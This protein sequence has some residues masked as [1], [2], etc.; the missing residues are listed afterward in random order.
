MGEK[1]DGIRN[2]EAFINALNA[3]KYGGYSDWR[4]PTIQELSSIVNHS[5][6]NLS[7]NTDYFPNTQVQVDQYVVIYWSSWP[8]SISITCSNSE[9][10]WC[11]DFRVGYDFNCKKSDSNYVRAVR[12]GQSVPFANLVVSDNETLSDTSTGLMLQQTSGLSMMTWKDA[13]SYCENLNLAGYTD[14]RLP[15]INELRFLINLHLYNCIIPNKDILFSNFN[16]YWSSSS[17][18][19]S[20]AWIGG[21][22]YGFGF[23][24]PKSWIYYVSCVR[25]GNTS[26][27]T[28]NIEIAQ[29]PLAGQPGTIFTQYGTG[30]TPN[31]KITLHI[32]DEPNEESTYITTARADGGFEIRFDSKE[33]PLGKYRWY[34]TDD[35]TGNRS[36]NELTYEITKDPFP[37]IGNFPQEGTV[38][39]VFEQIGTGFTP[40]NTATLVFMDENRNETGRREVNIDANGKFSI[41]YDPDDNKQ[42]GR[43]FWYAKDNAT[44]NTALEM[45]YRIVPAT[46]VPVQTN[47]RED[48]KAVP[49]KDPIKP[50]PGVL[51][52]TNEFDPA[53]PVTTI[54]VHGWNPDNLKSMDDVDWM[55][56]M[57]IFLSQSGKTNVL[58]YNWLTE[59]ASDAPPSQDRISEHGSILA[60][61]L[62]SQ[63][64]EKG[65]YS[66]KLH[67]IGHSAGAGVSYN[68][69]NV[70]YDMN[71][72]IPV[73]H[74]TMLDAFLFDGDKALNELK[75]LPNWSMG[76]GIPIIKATS[77]AFNYMP[78]SK[79]SF[80]DNYWT[81]VG[82]LSQ[83]FTIFPAISI[84][85]QGTQANI[86]DSLS[87]A[88]P[89]N[90]GML[91][92][93]LLS[94][95]DRV[96]DTSYFTKPEGFI[97]YF[98]DA[99]HATPINWYMASMVDQLRIAD[100][101]PSPNYQQH[102][103][104]YY[105][106]PVFSDHKRPA[107]ADLDYLV[108]VENNFRL[109]GSSEVLTDLKETAIEVGLEIKEGVET[110]IQ[111]G[112]DL[113]NRLEKSAEEM[114]TK[115]KVVAAD[116]F[117]SASNWVSSKTSNVIHK[118]KDGFKFFWMKSDSP[119]SLATDYAIPADAPFMA[120]SYR[121]LRADG[122]DVIDVFINDEMVYSK[123]AADDLNKD[124][125]LSEWINVAKWAGQT[126]LLTFRIYSADGEPIEIEL[127]D[128]VFA[129]LGDIDKAVKL[130]SDKDGMP[131]LWEAVYLG[132]TNQDGT[133]DAD[134]DGIRDIDEYKNG[135]DPLKAESGSKEITAS[136]TANAGTDQTVNERSTVTLQGSAVSG[137]VSYQWTMAGKA[138]DWI[139]TPTL[140]NPNSPNPTF[141]AP[142]V[143]IDGG[144][145]VFQLI[146]TDST[147][148]QSSDVCD[149]RI[150]NIDS[151]VSEDAEE[152]GLCFISSAGNV[153][154]GQS[155]WLLMGV[156]AVFVFAVRRN[157]HEHCRNSS[158]N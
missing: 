72:K 67:F 6:K 120:F 56:N 113:K 135:T 142:E 103:Y 9:W 136:V 73:D 31:G 39:T 23:S 158:G 70:L 119:V 143:G 12:G 151:D 149:I 116:A 80:I 22:D 92:F 10:E 95:E 11:M 108:G 45:E 41:L 90:Q 110:V 109:F 16:S 68:A 114:A 88:H 132:N 77:S 47:V 4:L 34:A 21:L 54:L 27:I 131:D 111:K 144:S 94:L 107:K 126:V 102:Q 3:V 137:A 91:L 28:S 82:A 81:S 19:T 145:M 38:Y 37:E 89:M 87:I 13:L 155:F 140:S 8:S 32:F 61:L 1:G 157:S 53:L 154:E 78:L 79:A 104:G 20:W 49:N 115:V 44:T 55:K 156:F 100:R 7:I 128:L 65:N 66:G 48:K 97:G 15:N 14:W 18:E 96:K 125:V 30:F 148:K 152:G 98:F 134:K 24:R 122:T 99:Q 83:V 105:W 51:E 62:K 33:K 40:G 26:P 43:Y 2:T 153:P 85:Y 146:V 101:S 5:R 29:R 46:S 75:K 141:T 36:R 76:V 58:A 60:D 138:P 42:P 133:G 147:G 59:A 129:Q 106:S 35:A 71:P 52:W 64:A 123:T 121:V 127:Y 50:Q 93:S 139:S 124:I 117:D 69:V 63:F 74:L 25:G 150:N 86:L 57:K 84:T 17:E 112:K 130:D 118:V